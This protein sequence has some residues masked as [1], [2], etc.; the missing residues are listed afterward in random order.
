MER[1]GGSRDRLWER[2]GIANSLKS[3]GL[4]AFSVN[5]DLGRI[6]SLLDRIGSLLERLVSVLERLE[7]PCER[8]GVS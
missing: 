7:A 1:L 8:L 2:F 5:A 6:G 3:I 4:Q